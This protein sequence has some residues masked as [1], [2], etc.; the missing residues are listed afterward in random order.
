QLA[1]H[2]R[3]PAFVGN[4]SRT[5]KRSVGCG[6]RPPPPPAPPPKPGGGEPITATCLSPLSQVLGEGLAVGAP[7]ADASGASPTTAACPAARGA[8]LFIRSTPTCR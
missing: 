6:A 1:N 3:A 7:I 8:L 4:N 5:P 2:S